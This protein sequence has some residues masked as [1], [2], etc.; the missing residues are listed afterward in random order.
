MNGGAHKIGRCNPIWGNAA[1]YLQTSSIEDSPWDCPGDCW[2]SPF[3]IYPRML[4][5]KGVT[6]QCFSAREGICELSLRAW[7]G[8]VGQ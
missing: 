2:K 4:M 7:Q 8:F 6:E 5:G 3:D 1:S